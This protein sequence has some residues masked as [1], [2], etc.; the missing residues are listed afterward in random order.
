MPV[1]TGM[2]RSSLA[3]GAA[4]LA[5][6]L[7]SCSSSKKNSPDTTAP[8]GTTTSA[9]APSSAAGGIVISG[10]AYSGTLTVK[11]GEKVTVTNKDSVAHTLTDVGGK[12]DTGNIAGSGA[13]GTFTAPTAP[14]SYQLKCTY[15]PRMKG[16]LV[17][18]A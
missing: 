13:T 16:S 18:K 5:I 17:V 12:F 6:L 7:A 4:A 11:P 10:F 1:T 2:N 15:H 9:A 3:A 8:A 14:G